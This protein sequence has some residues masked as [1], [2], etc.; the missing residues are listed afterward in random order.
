[1][2]T[3]CCYSSASVTVRFVDE[4]WLLNV[5]LRLHNKYFCLSLLYL[6]FHIQALICCLSQYFE[7][8]P[9]CR[10]HM[11]DFMLFS[12]ICVCVSRQKLLS[13]LCLVSN[14]GDQEK[15][16]ADILV[17]VTPLMNICVCVCV[18]LCVCMSVCVCVCVCV[19][20]SVCV[21]VCVCLCV[22][23]C[24]SVSVCL[25]VWIMM[26]WVSDLLV[27][28]RMNRNNFGDPL[29][30]LLALPSGQQLHLRVLWFKTYTCRSATSWTSCW[31]IRPTSDSVSRRIDEV[32]P[33]V[34]VCV[35][36]W[37]D[38]GITQTHFL[39]YLCHSLALFL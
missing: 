2:E 31:A 17:A 28:L 20:V 24:L 33:Q 38:P 6:L 35:C 37:M 34:C 22:C 4:L 30:F 10:L 29:T 12:L 39:G 18:C 16:A 1:M 25:S 7:Y 36:A 26:K 21:C 9:M 3:L 8:K 5:F 15:E 27:P 23:L 32:K 11:G 13:T 14:S 19:C